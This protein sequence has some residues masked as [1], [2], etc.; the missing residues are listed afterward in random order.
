MC[1][2]PHHGAKAIGVFPGGFRAELQFL[3]GQFRR[4]ENDVL[5]VIEFP[6]AREDAAFSSETFMERQ[7]SGMASRWRT[8]ADQSGLDPNSAVLRN[9]SGSS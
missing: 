2:A 8:A 7:C 9:T 1:N 3:D 6:V 5:A 4:T